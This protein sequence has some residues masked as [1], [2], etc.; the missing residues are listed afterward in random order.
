MIGFRN[1]DMAELLIHTLTERVAITEGHLFRVAFAI[2]FSSVRLLNSGRP[3]LPR[4]FFFPATRSVYDAVLTWIFRYSSC[5]LLSLVF[6]PHHHLLSFGSRG[7]DVLRGPAFVPLGIH[8]H[9]FENL[10][11]MGHHCHG[12]K[13]L[14]RADRKS[15]AC[16]WA[17]SF[18][19]C[20]FHPWTGGDGCGCLCPGDRGLN[21]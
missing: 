19:G 21:W 10:R 2:F 1:V 8:H 3:T 14:S 9:L 6:S 20:A 15:F 16:F 5:F 7:F 11:R 12:R 17:K 13:R 4:C 18:A